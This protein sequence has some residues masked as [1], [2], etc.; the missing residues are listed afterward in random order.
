MT[1]H[2][3]EEVQFNHCKREQFELEMN[4]FNISASVPVQSKHRM[5]ENFTVIIFH[6]KEYIR[7]HTTD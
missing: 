3:K 4:N 5:N 7:R 6:F 2:Y 1:V